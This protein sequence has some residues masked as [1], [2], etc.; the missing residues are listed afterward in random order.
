MGWGRP[1]GLPVKSAGH[2]RKGVRCSNGIGDPRPWHWPWF[3][4]ERVSSEGLLVLAA[5]TIILS[6][7]AI[8]GA[9]LT[10]QSLQ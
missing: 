6:V 2:C 10:V 7:M 1:K 3:D 8:L 4:R 5:I 9:A